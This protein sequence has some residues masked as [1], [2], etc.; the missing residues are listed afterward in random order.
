MK[1]V[2]VDYGIKGMHDDNI[3]VPLQIVNQIISVT[4]LDNDHYLHLIKQPQEGV[5][6][7]LFQYHDVLVYKYSLLQSTSRR[8]R[9][10]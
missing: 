5:P 8:S 2:E 7:S 6:V 4:E 10:K 1:S 3:A 9:L